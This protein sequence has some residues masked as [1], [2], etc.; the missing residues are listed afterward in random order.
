[1]ILSGGVEEVIEFVVFREESR[2]CY[3][4][5]LLSVL[6]RVKLYVSVIWR[7]KLIVDERVVGICFGKWLYVL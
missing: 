6:W 4:S 7:R 5:L 1:V 2:A 3:C